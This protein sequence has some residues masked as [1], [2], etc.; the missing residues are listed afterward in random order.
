MRETRFAGWSWLKGGKR[1]TSLL[2]AAWQILKTI[3]QAEQNE[4]EGWLR[5]LDFA[6]KRGSLL[7][8]PGLVFAR[9]RGPPFIAAGNY[10][11]PRNPDGFFPILANL[12]IL[13]SSPLLTFLFGWDFPLSICTKSG[14]LEL[15]TPFPAAA[16]VGSSTLGYLFPSLSWGSTNKGK[17][18]G[19]YAGLKGYSPSWQLIC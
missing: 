4:G 16:S 5:L 1:W 13:F 3:C 7:S 19:I 15:K 6:S 12:P 2:P 9:W 11:F 18:L 8:Q 14:V 10:P 17:Q